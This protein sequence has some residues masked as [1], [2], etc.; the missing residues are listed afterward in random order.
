MDEVSMSRPLKLDIKE[1]VADL[2]TLLGQQKT[3]QGKERVQ[4]L[5][6]LKLGEKKTITALATLLG[7]HRVTIQDWLALYRAGG[8]KALLAEKHARGRQSS[9][10]PWAVKALHKRLQQPEGFA[11][12]ERIQQWLDDTLGVKA[13]Y[14]AV[15]RLAHYKLKAKLKVAKRQSPEQDPEKVQLFKVN[16][17]DDVTLLRRYCQEQLGTPERPVRFWVQDETRWSLTTICRRLITVPGIKAVDCFQ[18]KREGYWLY[19]LVEPLSGEQFYYEFSHLDSACF[20]E[21]L[22]VFATTYPHQWHI[23]QLDQASAHTAKKLKVPENVILMFQPSH[24]PELNPIERLWLHLKNSMS[25]RL[26][27]SVEHLRLAVRE[28]LAHL[29]AE[30]VQS[31]TAW[32]YIRDALFVAGIS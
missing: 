32:D 31:L 10:P 26:F 4:A 19:G 18:W 1:S 17:G 21:Y 13:S 9:I 23:L 8:M 14:A 24:A 27:E 20:Q 16:L 11:S 12:Y 22:D 2:K 3:A 6:L 30:V 7:R 29:S 25:W 28:Q 15:Y 5:Y